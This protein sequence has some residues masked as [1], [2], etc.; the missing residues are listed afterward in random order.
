MLP[1]DSSLNGL[2]LVFFSFPVSATVDLFM[3]RIG[4]KRSSGSYG[5][6]RSNRAI[7]KSTVVA[8]WIKISLKVKRISQLE[9]SLYVYRQMHL[10]D[11]QSYYF[12]LSP[13]GYPRAVSESY[14][15]EMRNKYQSSC[16]HSEAF[17]FDRHQNPLH[18]ILAGFQRPEGRD[19]G[20]LVRSGSKIHLKYVNKVKT[21]YEYLNNF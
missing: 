1:L 7:V 13:P 18:A 14:L 11:Y 12:G 8:I 17:L 10:L 19:A 3:S 20:I 16:E 9:Q 6:I 4:P 5:A 21:K 2:L 15:F